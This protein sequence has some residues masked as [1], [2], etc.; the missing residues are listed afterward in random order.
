VCVSCDLNRSN[1]KNRPT[2]RRRRSFYARN[3]Y[4]RTLCAREPFKYV[5]LLFLHTNSLEFRLLSRDDQLC[6]VVR[7]RI[8]GM[9]DCRPRFV[10]VSRVKHNVRSVPEYTNSD[11]GEKGL[12]FFF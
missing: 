6:D 9:L 12:V 8:T 4:V 2:K 11:D 7:T 1:L 5:R 10:F 3:V